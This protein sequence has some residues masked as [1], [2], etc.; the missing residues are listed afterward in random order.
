MAGRI[1]RN[2]P[3]SPIT[4]RGPDSGTG[5]AARGTGTSGAE[6]LGARAGDTFASA[7][8]EAKNAADRARL[9]ELL[10]DV[11]RWSRRLK[12]HPTQ[13]NLKEYKRSVKEFMERVMKDGLA[14]TRSDSR[15]GPS[16][17]IYVRVQKIDSTLTELTDNFVES[18]SEPL[19][20]MAK[21]D[22]IRGLLLDLVA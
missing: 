21:I 16:Q 12:D 9:D 6:V 20:L 13:T 7:L 22:E 14:V 3:V 5:A 17:K 18:Q 4:P 8:G 19:D 11:D 15:F 1:D 10:M 2:S